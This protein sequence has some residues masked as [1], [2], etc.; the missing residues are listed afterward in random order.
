MRITEFALRKNPADM[1]ISNSRFDYS[2][3]RSNGVARPQKR[4]TMAGVQVIGLG[5]GGQLGRARWVWMEPVQRGCGVD[6]IA[7]LF[8][9][10]CS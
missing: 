10:P 5:L 2:K 8:R 6:G 3:V 7:P 4:H 9:L 1:A